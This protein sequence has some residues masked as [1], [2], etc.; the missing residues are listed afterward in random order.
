MSNIHNDIIKEKIYEQVLEI[1]NPLKIKIPSWDMDLLNTL[2]Q[3][4]Y[5]LLVD[6]LTEHRWANYCD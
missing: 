4:E 2:T 3:E 5:D 1:L 6:T